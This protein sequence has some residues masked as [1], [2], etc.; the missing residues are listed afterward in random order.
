MAEGEEM[1]RAEK[2]N[3]SDR[4]REGTEA[5]EQR[6]EKAADAPWLVWR[7]ARDITDPMILPDLG[8]SASYY[9]T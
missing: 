8:L 4:G 1:R 9:A 5:T 3:S 6:P 2:T 7:A